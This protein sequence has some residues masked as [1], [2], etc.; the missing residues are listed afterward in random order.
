M[1]ARRWRQLLGGVLLLSYALLVHYSNLGRTPP[2]LGA[3]L[4]LAPLLLLLASGLRRAHWSTVAL[5]LT[6]G[7]LLLWGA[8]GALERHFDWIYLGQQCALYAALALAFG[9]SLRPGQTPLCTRWATRLRG[10]LNP[11]ALRYTRAVTRLWTAFFTLVVAA[12]LLLYGLAARSV[13]S[14]FVNLL[15]LPAALLLF[16]AEF[17]WRRR[18]LP[19][20]QHA[21]LR[22]MT[23]LFADLSQ[24]WRRA[25]SEPSSGP[26]R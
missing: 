23:R 5:V 9:R 2:L 14:L 8:W 16:V 1:T 11:E 21:S 13:W 15:I 18:S 25:P 19:D 6:A 3:L 17:L 10:P 20:T 22:D 12:T 7:A 24:L 26:T 4:A